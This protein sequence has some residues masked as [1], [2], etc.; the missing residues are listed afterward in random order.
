MRRRITFLTLVASCCLV[1]SSAI[2]SVQYDATVTKEAIWGLGNSNRGFTVVQDQDNGIELGLRAKLRY[3]SPDDSVA[4]IMSQG[5]GTY[6]NF[7]AGGFG[8]GGNFAS[9]NID[10][11]INS[12]YNGSGAN[13][14]A[15]TYTLQIDQD[16]GWNATFT[17]AYFA[18]DPI[19]G[20]GWAD[21]SFGDNT[22]DQSA[23]AE[24]PLLDST[25][26]G[27]LVTTSNLVQNSFNFQFF[28]LTNWFDPTVDGRYTVQLTAFDQAGTQLAQN[29]IHVQVGNGVVPEPAS[30]LTWGGIISCVGLVRRRRVG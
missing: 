11:S 12:N 3:P 25:T 6:G 30:L 17:N 1:G 5:N 29:T 20:L 28:D 23:G 14:D 19:N 10:W 21:H 7:P 24:A 9:W 22:T 15:Y 26:Y 13:L 27:N 18:S 8:S 2:A 4:G 16:P